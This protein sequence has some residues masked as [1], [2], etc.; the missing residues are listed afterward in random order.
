M[1]FFEKISSEYQGNKHKTQVFMKQQLLL[2]E[3]VEGLGR[4]GDLV[5]AK[6]GFTRNFLLPKKK[7]VIAG[8]HT[9]KLQAGLKEERQ[10]QA[11]MDRK[12]AEEMTAKLVDFVITT[13]VKV[14]PE[15]KMYGSVSILNIVE[16]M[17]ENGYTIDRKQIELIHPIKTTGDHKI[18]LKLKEDVSAAFTLK[19]LPEGGFPEEKEEETEEE[20]TEEE[21]TEEVKENE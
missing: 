8:K 9:L 17:K 18:H 19:I 11:A 2:L 5:S 3:D 4:T 7:A 10:K 13:E 14:D 1:L 16:L 21:K 15:G 20:K 12:E 6:P